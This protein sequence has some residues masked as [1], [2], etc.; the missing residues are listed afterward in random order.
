MSTEFFWRLPLGSDGHDLASDKNTRGSAIY[1]PGNI[2]PGRL[3]NGEPDGFTY[4][5]YI[6]QVAKAAELAGFE[7]AL[8]PT[9][10]EP[11]IAAA[12]LAR[13]TRRIKFLIAFQATWT[14]PAYAAQQAAIL[15]NL[16]HGR[17]DWNII[18]GGNPASQRA[19]GDFLEHDKR[20]QRTGEFLDIIKGLWENESFS[21]QGDIYQLENGSLPRGLNKERKPG[22]YFS[23]FSDP[24]LD[25]A[26]RHADVYLNWAEPVDKLKPHIERVR[27]LADK[28]GREVRFGIRID[29]FA[30]ETEEAAWSDLRRQYERIDAKTSDFIKNFASGSDSVGAARQTAYHQNS[31][32]FEDLIIGPNLWAGFGKAKPGPTI[33]LVGSHENVAE[34]LAEY[35]D[36][37]FST[38]ILAGNPHLEEALR[39]GQEVLPLVHQRPVAE[40]APV[41]AG[42][43][44][45]G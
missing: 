32:R 25:V 12:A 21:Y 3:P 44:A 30:R 6:A 23:G 9:G 41:T 2:A 10:P 36:A 29:L 7:G 13:E 4:I 35:R 38:F 31:Q 15:Q 8:L 26:A 34:R 33:G 11:W 14:L 27:E 1:R 22:V 17:L 39:I 43:K 28:Q 18:T 19:N 16:S 5:D 45:A 24:A 40:T 42:L 37:G 20:Y